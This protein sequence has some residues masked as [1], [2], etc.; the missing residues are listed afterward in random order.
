MGKTVSRTIAATYPRN[1]MADTRTVTS[2]FTIMRFV[3]NPPIVN[4]SGIFDGNAKEPNTYD[5]NEPRT[6]PTAAAIIK[7][8][9][10]GRIFGISKKLNIFLL[11]YL[12]EYIFVALFP[13]P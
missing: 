12:T 6:R 11:H 9:V 13:C 1:I 5:R 2:I 8:S 10:S 3:E 7:V 4:S